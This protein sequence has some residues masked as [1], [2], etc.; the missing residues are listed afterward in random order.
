MGLMGTLEKIDSI[1]IIYHYQAS[2]ICSLSWLLTHWPLG[3]K[4]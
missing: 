4:Q 2:A 3:T 1:I